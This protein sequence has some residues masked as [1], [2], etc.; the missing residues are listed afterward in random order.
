[1]GI[2]KIDSILSFCTH[3]R[4][5]TDNDIQDYIGTNGEKQRFAL[6]DGVTNSVLPQLWAQLLVEDYLIVENTDDFPSPNLPSK[7]SLST[8]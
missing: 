3:K 8:A 4:G 7:L 5:E 2:Y 1:M 6:S